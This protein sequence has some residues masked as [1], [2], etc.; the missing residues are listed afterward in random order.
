ME[1][2]ITPQARLAAPSGA[3]VVRPSRRE[4]LANPAAFHDR[5]WLT[6][7]VLCVS[8]LVIVIDNTIVNVAL[9]TLQNDLGT[10]ITG[11]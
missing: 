3:R 10:S 9:P 5:R 6:L 7:V 4:R 11:L 1:H 8:L 2:L